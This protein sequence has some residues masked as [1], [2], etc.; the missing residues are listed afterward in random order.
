MKLARFG[1]SDLLEQSAVFCPVL[2]GVLALRYKS[3]GFSSCNF[4]ELAAWHRILSRSA[5]AHP[6]AVSPTAFLRE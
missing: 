3:A 4:A 2:Q 1:L 5:P 6:Q